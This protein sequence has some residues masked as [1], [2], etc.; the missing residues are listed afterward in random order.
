MAV[1]LEASGPLATSTEVGEWVEATAHGELAQ[2]AKFMSE[3]EQLDDLP[4]PG[5]SSHPPAALSPSS[6]PTVAVPARSQTAQTTSAA[7]NGEETVL[8]SGKSLVGWSRHWVDWVGMR[9]RRKRLAIAAGSSALVLAGLTWLLVIRPSPARATDEQA[10]SRATASA[11]QPSAASARTTPAPRPAESAALAPAPA[12]SG[13]ETRASPA[14]SERPRALPT[15]SA[16]PKWNNP[17]SSRPNSRP[18][19]QPP[20]TVDEVGHRHYKRECL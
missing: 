12:S 9:E 8:A 4:S 10:T 14:T 5:L 6:D 3:L 7:A 1:A 11:Q 19:C 2:R 17:A 16:S 20:Y 18:G 13:P 15:K